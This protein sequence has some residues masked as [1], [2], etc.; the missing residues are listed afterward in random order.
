MTL[1]CVLEQVP[2]RKSRKTHPFITERLLMGY[3]ETNQT[4]KVYLDLCRF[5]LYST[6]EGAGASW[7]DIG[8]P[9][10]ENNKK[11]LT[12]EW[13]AEFV[14]EEDQ[15]KVELSGKLTL[16]FEI[17]KMCEDIGDKV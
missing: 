3:K 12:S 1:R 13:W 8:V 2:S 17:L 5:V 6:E 15:Y 4:N 9:D 11:E 14:K 16:L 7:M 10:N